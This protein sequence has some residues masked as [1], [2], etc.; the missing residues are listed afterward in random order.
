VLRVREYNP[1]MPLQPEQA[2]V[3][4]DASLRSIKAEQAVT[5]RVIEA[6]PLD[7]GDFKLEEVGKSAIDLAWH[8][9]GA[10]HR[11]LD[12]VLTGTFDVTATGRPAHL[13]TS[14]AIA[15]WYAETSARDQERVAAAAGAD[16]VKIVDFRGIF[17]APAVTF[18]ETGLHHS[19]HHR[20]QLSTYL[21]PMGGKV[22][23]IY[24]ESYDTAKAK[25]GA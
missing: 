19:I 15:K 18:M 5:Q 9:V 11:F 2:L 17:K 14:A 6:I 1:D 7:K 13:D 25:A 12:C 24:G 4:R 22:P 23:S 8:I 21:R 16:L 20:G 3:L 10:E